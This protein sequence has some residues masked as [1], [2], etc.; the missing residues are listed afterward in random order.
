MSR[1]TPWPYL[2]HCQPAEAKRR[3]LSAYQKAGG[4]HVRAA[5]L[6]DLS[7]RQLGRYCAALRLTDEQLKTES[8]PIGMKTRR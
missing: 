6:L 7:T 3:I 5:K 1:F 8:Q 4:V 2:L